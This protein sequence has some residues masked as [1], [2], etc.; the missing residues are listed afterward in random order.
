M[1]PTERLGAKEAGPGGG[2]EARRESGSSRE[3]QLEGGDPA[4]WAD[5]LCPA[6][7]AVLTG[8]HRPRCPREGWE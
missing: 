8:G 7:G 5:L 2:A 6:C 4:C 1:A 3:E